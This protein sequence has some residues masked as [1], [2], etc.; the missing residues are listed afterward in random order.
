[1]SIRELDRLE[2]IFEVSIYVY[3]L[4]VNDDEDDLGAGNGVD[5]KLCPTLVRSGKSDTFQD[6]L[7]LLAYSGHF[8]LINDIEKLSNLISCHKCGTSKSRQSIFIH[9]ARCRGARTNIAFTHQKTTYSVSHTLADELKMYNIEVP[10]IL[11]YRKYRKYFAT[12][13][14]ETYVDKEQTDEEKE[15]EGENV[16]SPEVKTCSFINIFGMSKKKECT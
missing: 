14:I 16:M 15:E 1:M 4:G 3:R 8:C 11:K 7:H 5:V 9:Y 13:D 12:F 6:K 2:D 10:D